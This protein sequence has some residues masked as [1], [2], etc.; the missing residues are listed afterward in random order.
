MK[1]SFS[2]FYMIERD[3]GSM[4]SGVQRDE[5]GNIISAKA[6]IM[7]WMGKMNATLALLEGGKNDA[8]TGRVFLGYLSLF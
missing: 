2:E 3:F 6:T 1:H 5:N 4:L 7:R 8:G